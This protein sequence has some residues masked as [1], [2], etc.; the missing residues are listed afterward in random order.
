M[1]AE[2]NGG[3]T[4]AHIVLS[5]LKS[6]TARLVW[7]AGAAALLF[8]AALTTGAATGEEVLQPYSVQLHVHG[9][10]SEGLG[11]IDS[12]SREAADVGLD[13][14]WWSDHDWRLTTDDW[15]PMAGSIS[16]SRVEA[17]C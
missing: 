11:S 7:I 9:S 15:R 17:S 1:P 8:M 13:V 14:L 16:C 10:F 6:T 3:V 4:E 2:A 5:F 12:Q